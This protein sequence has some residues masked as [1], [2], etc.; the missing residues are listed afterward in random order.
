MLSCVGWIAAS[1]HAQPGAVAAPPSAAQG[2]PAP[3]TA[4]QAPASA[5]AQ[6]RDHFVLGRQLFEAHNFREALREFRLVAALA[7][8]AELWFNIGRAHEEL[9]EY[10]LAARAFER[11]LRDRVDA[12]DEAAVG[13][14][15]AEL[16]RLAQLNRERSLREPNSGSLRIHTKSSSALVL[17]DGQ[18]LEPAALAEPL[19]L[20]AGR[21][22][23]DV[24]E[25]RHI[26]MHAQL[27]IEPGLLTAAY[28]DLPPATEA[29][30][31]APTRGF[32]WSLLGLTAAG[33]ITSLVFGVLAV[34]QQADGDVGQAKAWAQRAD[35]ALAGTAVCAL[36]TAVLYYVEGRAAPTELTRAADRAAR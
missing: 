29:R 26:P 28:A 36:A 32:T 35:V 5:M 19:L 15:I 18:A 34:T 21:H 12:K 31:L 14:R 22:R 11:Y 27:D 25:A 4:A 9:A 6:A 13:A 17:L 20:P 30:T 2:T 24:S 7:P 16:D 10:D 1:A 23:L 3:R 33:A 8:N